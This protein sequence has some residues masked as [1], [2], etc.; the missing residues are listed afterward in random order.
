MNILVVAGHPADMFD[1]CGGTLLHHRQRGDRVTCVSMTQGLRVHDEVISDVFRTKVDQF[2]EEEIEKLLEERQKVKYAEVIKACNMFGVE[3]VRFLDF[4]D[5]ILTFNQDMI[6]RLAS[7]M[8]EVRPDILITHWPHQF[9]GISNHHAITGQI[10]IAAADAA[11]GVNFKDR[12]PACR[13][14]QT[15]FML[16]PADCSSFDLLSVNNVAHTQFYVDV[17]DVIELKVKAL[18]SM[19]SQKY[20]IR[21]H[22]KV[23]AERWYGTFGTR[24]SLPYAEGFAM[25][26]PE[27]GHYLP[28]SEHRVWLATADEHDIMRKYCTLQAVYTEL[29]EVD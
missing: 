23:M 12:R 11:S 18:N 17:S 5:E 25:R 29:D 16:S 22:A 24:V 1:H 8:R 10:A 21:N 9:G 15:F 4:D 3:D 7:L 26:S 6:S 14:A 19:Q 20:D 2:T 27:V 28:L 13:I